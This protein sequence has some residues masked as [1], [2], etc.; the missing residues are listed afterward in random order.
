MW[1]RVAIA[2][3]AGGCGQVAG[4]KQSDAGTG[5]ASLP[6]DAVAYHG[7]LAATTPQPFG[8]KPYCDYTITLQQLSLDLVVIPS[9]SGPGMVESGHA[10]ALN[11]EAN[12]PKLCPN[13][14]I[15]V[16][17]A[18]Y[19]FMP[20]SPVSAATALSFTGDPANAPEVTLAVQLSQAGSVYQASLGFHR[21]DSTIESLNW[22]VLATVSLA[23]H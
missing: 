13:G 7:A 4:S 3:L 18:R 20:A 22:S 8:G 17:I 12:D 6:P 16:K 15:P 14:T 5:D 2:M 9:T 23:Q 10:E 21:D 11:V 1:T 19:N